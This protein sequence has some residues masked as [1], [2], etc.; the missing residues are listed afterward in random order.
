MIDAQF[1][2]S[3]KYLFTRSLLREWSSLLS[4]L[5]REWC[6]KNKNQPL[7]KK[8]QHIPVKILDKV[9]IIINVGNIKKEERIPP[10]LSLFFAW[11]Y[12]KTLCRITVFPWKKE[13]K[14]EVC[15]VCAFSACVLKKQKRWWWWWWEW[16]VE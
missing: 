10:S 12:V 16:G 14:G 13:N 4:T 8:L 11:I 7:E 6:K 1:T 5:T 9:I 15:M 2:L 3:H